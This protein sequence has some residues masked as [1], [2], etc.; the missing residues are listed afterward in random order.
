[1]DNVKL[2]YTGRKPIAVELAHAEYCAALGRC[3]CHLLPVTVERTGAD[4]TK[5]R[6]T[7]EAPRPSS[8][9]LLPGVET[10]PVPRAVLRVARIAAGVQD[11]SI[12]VVELTAALRE[13]AKAAPR[14]RRAQ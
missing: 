3:A 2:I 11:K 12:R 14:R 8:L 13:P 4:G 5:T 1:M 7:K 10:A 9:H 6:Y